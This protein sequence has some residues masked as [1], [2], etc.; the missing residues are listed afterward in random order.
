M[1]GG[2]LTGIGFLGKEGEKKRQD[3]VIC[4]DEEHRRLIE[5]RRRKW[6]AQIDYRRG[7]RQV[8]TVFAHLSKAQRWGLARLPR[9]NRACRSRRTRASQ[10]STRGSVGRSGTDGLSTLTGVVSL[11]R[12]E[13]WEKATGTGS[14][15]VFCTLAWMGRALDRGGAGRKASSGFRFGCDQSA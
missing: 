8:S 15:H 1:G 5:D 12:A 9:R 10:C 2:P 14:G 11:S 3:R 6:L 7:Q 13:K 4:Y